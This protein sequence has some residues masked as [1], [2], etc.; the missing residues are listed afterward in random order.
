MAL[1]EA[2]AAVLRAMPRTAASAVMA[3]YSVVELAEQA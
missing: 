1:L 2:A 3:A